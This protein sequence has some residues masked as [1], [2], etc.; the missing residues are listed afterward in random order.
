MTIPPRRRVLYIR[1]KRQIAISES[2]RLNQDEWV[3]AMS[4]LA[5]VTLKDEDFDLD[6]ACN[7]LRPDFILY[8]SPTLYPV[9]LTIK[10]I[11]AHPQI[12]RIAF[13]MQD[14]YCATRVNFLRTIEKM[15]I[16]WIFTHMPEI[17]LRQS[18]ELKTRT[19]SVPHI[20]DDRVFHDYK[21][22]KDIPVSVFGGFLAPELYYWRAETARFLPDHFPT[23]IY[24][25]PGYL[26]PVPRHKFPVS[27]EKYA[28]L[29]NRS[30]F[31]LA[32]TTRFDYL[33]RKHLEI[34]ASGAVLVAPDAPSLRPYG[35]RD[36]ENCILGSGD[37]LFDKIKKVA[38]DPE[39][40]EKIRKNGYDF[41]HQK[42][43]RKHWR[44]ILN[45]YEVLRNLKPGQTIKQQDLYGDFIA[46]P[47]DNAFTP[48]IIDDYPDSEVSAITKLWL[49]AI[50]KG[51]GLNQIESRMSELSRW[52]MNMTEHW[53]PIG[54]MA[55]LK[56][57][58]PGAKGFFLKPQ[59]IRKIEGGF[60]EY[61]PEEIAWLSLTASLSGD[62]DLLKLTR[63]ESENL[64][65]LSLRR[66]QWLG[67][68]LATGCGMSN[69]PQGVLSRAKDD[70]LSVHWTGQLNLKDWLGLISRILNANGQSGSL[71]T[72]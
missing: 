55:L 65:H 53:I 6:K 64:R 21:L 37:E 15:N 10:N 45:F 29:L 11:T 59:E 68:I 9:A 69:P 38:D 67:Q 35:F 36:M 27:G 30:F 50:L 8:E 3:E 23:L 31:S 26:A 16:H 60:T 48:A 17:A 19:F 25:H 24:T 32:D 56:G 28:R 46:V 34:P 70:C 41:V 54:V 22:E 13:Q 7:D 47:E 66:M 71:K 58:L 4:A 12:P 49:Q 44:G 33:V 57:D 52:F 18:P 61:D 39:L 20:F 62:A 72:G 42:Y 51:D 1:H 40:Y 63:Q 14:P 5:D 43:T 2:F